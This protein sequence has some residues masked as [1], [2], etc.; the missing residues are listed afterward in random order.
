MGRPLN[1]E[2]LERMYL[3]LKRMNMTPDFLMALMNNPAIDA[4]FC[5][6]LKLAE[7]RS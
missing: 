2:A 7:G 4:E 3:L 6:V 1:P 5:A